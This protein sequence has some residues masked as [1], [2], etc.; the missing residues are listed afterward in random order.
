MLK[1]HP[2]EKLLPTRGARMAAVVILTIATVWISWIM[3]RLVRGISPG[4]ISFEF[5]GTPENANRILELW[6]T[7][8]EARMLAH[9]ALD[10]WW[11]AFYSTALALLCVM[12]AI[13]L[14]AR[15]PRWAQLGVYFAW[16]AWLA[17]LLDRIENFVLVRMI[18]GNV[19][20]LWTSIAF[21]CAA[22][23]FG[24]VLVCLLYIIGSPFF[25]RFAFFSRSDN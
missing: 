17:A 23:K 4:I 7:S 15:A 5:A 2:L 3:R 19:N 13:R 1:K 24:I 10:N 16:A 11:L 14:R 6:G 22:A 8:G 9:I 21:G 25:R 12:V 18:D 20:H